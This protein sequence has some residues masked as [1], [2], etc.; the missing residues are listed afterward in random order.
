MTPDGKAGRRSEA[1]MQLSPVLQLM[2]ELGAD[3]KKQTKAMAASHW[4][5]PM[6]CSWVTGFVL[7]LNVFGLI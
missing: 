4:A 3:S 1:D 7:T 5:T 6:P 2:G